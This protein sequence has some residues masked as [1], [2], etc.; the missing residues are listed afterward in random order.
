MPPP[1]SSRMGL[2]NR[3]LVPDKKTPISKASI[4]AGFILALVLA[5]IVRL[6][7]HAFWIFPMRVDTKSMEP[8][9]GP[10]QTVYVNRRAALDFGSMVLYRHENGRFLLGRLAA[11]PG[12][13]V[14]MRDKKLF[15]NG[16]VVTEA[17][18]T[19]TEGGQTIGAVVFPRDHAPE[20][21]LGTDL[22]FIL[23]DD[24]ERCMDSRILGP[25]RR[26]Q[27]VGTI[28]LP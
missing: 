1:K 16:A 28:S 14:G 12:E 3:N 2:R 5:W 23:C 17:W 25:A 10:G 27:I 21:T 11:L 7:V 22:Y 4:A 15:R 9:L 26:D 19:N 20:I 24:R 13:R 6:V 18:Q 8:A